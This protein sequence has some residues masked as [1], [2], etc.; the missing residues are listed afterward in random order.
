MFN[1]QD[2]RALWN[3]PTKLQLWAG[4]VEGFSGSRGV[5]SEE[6]APLSLGV[7]PKAWLLAEEIGVSGSLNPTLS[8]SHGINL[9]TSKHQGGSTLSF[10]HM[11][12]RDHGVL[13]RDLI[14]ANMFKNET[15][16]FPPPP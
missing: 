2:T 5:G 7:L 1:G 12:R 9:S 16:E 14:E 15:Q 3:P 4:A 8:P 10:I 13:L 6:E 11:E